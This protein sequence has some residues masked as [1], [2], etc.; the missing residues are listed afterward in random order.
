MSLKLITSWQVKRLHVLKQAL[1]M[2]EDAYRAALGAY[3]VDTCKHLTA[4]EAA[5][6]INLFEMQAFKIGIWKMREAAPAGSKR[7]EEY[8]KRPGMASPKQLRML[9]AMWMGVSRQPTRGEKE[10]ALGHFIKRITGVDHLR[11]LDAV[12][13]RKVI[14]AIEAMQQG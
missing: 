2:P 12:D 6:L 13:A 9:E 8:G 7:F 3:R 1:R 4:V 10:L 14:K 5:S 11:F